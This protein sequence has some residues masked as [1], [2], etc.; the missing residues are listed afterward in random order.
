MRSKTGRHPVYYYRKVADLTQ[1]EASLK[2]GISRGYLSQIEVGVHP[3]NY[4]LAEKIAKAFSVPMAKVLEDASKWER[5]QGRE[6]EV[7][8]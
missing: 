7:T 8:R 2:M 6:R 5:K 4:R 1:V 3:M